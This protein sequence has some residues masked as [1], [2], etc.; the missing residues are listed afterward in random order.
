MWIRNDYFTCEIEHCSER[1]DGYV[2]PM[3]DA[4]GWPQECY[5]EEH[6]D[7]KEDLSLLSE[8]L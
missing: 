6:E 4:E 3:S 1:V 5:A 8:D 2:S 7:R